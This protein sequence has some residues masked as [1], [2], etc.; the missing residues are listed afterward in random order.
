MKH[1]LTVSIDISPK[2]VPSTAM[3]ENSLSLHARDYAVINVFNL[4]GRTKE[5]E[6]LTFL[7]EINFHR[8]RIA[9]SAQSNILLWVLE[10]QV[11]TIGS[12]PKELEP[13]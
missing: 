7:R 12:S 4:E 11:K 8:E 6:L 1:Y 9:D 5:D 2:N 10:Y 3:F 13:V